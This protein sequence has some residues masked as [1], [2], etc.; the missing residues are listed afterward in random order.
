VE[1]ATG[2][3]V[4]EKEFRASMRA[5]WPGARIHPYL[6]GARRQRIDQAAAT[7]MQRQISYEGYRY[8]DSVRPD[9][10][11]VR[12]YFAPRPIVNGAPQ[13]VAQGRVKF[14]AW[15]AD[16]HPEWVEWRGERAV[17]ITEILDTG[18]AKGLGLR[19]GDLIWSVSGQRVHNRDE[20]RTGMS[21]TPDAGVPVT[22]RRY[23]REP[24]GTP[25]MLRAPDGT[26]LLGDSGHAMWVMEELQVKIGDG[27]LG[28]RAADGAAPAGPFR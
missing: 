23:A 28:L 27:S 25:R 12:R 4:V 2:L 16:R 24:D 3:T 14:A 22:I 10:R 20:L 21:D 17:E 11:A 6:Q 13:G 9:G 8:T 5:D 1:A 15:W 7:A 19:V 26:L 18:Q